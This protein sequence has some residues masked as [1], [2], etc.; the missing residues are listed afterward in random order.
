M[1]DTY[2]NLVIAQASAFKDRSAAI[3]QGRDICGVM[4]YARGQ[5]TVPATP[6]VNDKL[7]LV[8]AEAVPLGAVFEP[9]A[10]WVYCEGDPGTALTLD[11]G[12]PSNPD[13]LADALA[14]TVI[15]TTSGVVTFDK[16]GTMPLGISDPITITE[17]ER[18]EATVKVSTAVDQTVLQFC[19]AYR[20][21]A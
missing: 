9:A 14:L 7:I 13:S 19:I 12:T 8:P 2:S 18:V 11:I 6:D 3:T 15:G 20:A 17:A 21:T 10:S 16:S 5:V 1:S 4:L